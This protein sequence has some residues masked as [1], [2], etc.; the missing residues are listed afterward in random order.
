MPLHRFPLAAIPGLLSLSPAVAAPYASGVTITGDS[1]TFILNESADSLK[2][3]FNEGASTLVIGTNPEPSGTKT[4]SKAGFTSFRIEVE[5]N[6]GPGW[7][8]GVLQQISEDTN[9]LVKFANGRGV[10]IN[11]FP[12]TGRFRAH[13]YLGRNHRQCRARGGAANTR[14]DN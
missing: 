4:F 10:A 13:R 2:V 9:N 8:S 14:T 3:V 1:V 6:A 5:K 7:K 12:N 11:R